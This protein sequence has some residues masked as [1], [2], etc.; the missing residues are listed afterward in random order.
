M[1]TLQRALSATEYLIPPP[2]SFAM[3]EA[4]S[5]CRH[6]SPYG[7]SQLQLGKANCQ[8]RLPCHLSLFTV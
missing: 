1:G 5:R 8:E 7:G 3:M 6:H 2:I 4:F